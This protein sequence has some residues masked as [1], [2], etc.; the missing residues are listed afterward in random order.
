MTN[1]KL[2]RNE[3]EAILAGVCAG[4]ADYFDMDV[5]LVRV[6]FLL[7]MIGGG[8]GLLVYIILWIVAPGKE[9]GVIMVDKEENIKDF[10]DKVGK[11]AKVMTKEIK[12]EVKSSKRSGSFLGLILMALGILILLEKMIPM[13]IRWDY[14]WPIMLIILGGYLIFRD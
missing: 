6:V 4:L 11:K 2:Y 3:S 12:K 8:S 9:D 14:I 10:A 7:L 13:V 1:R 5:T